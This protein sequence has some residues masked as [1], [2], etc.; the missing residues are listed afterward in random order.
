MRMSGWVAATAMF[1]LA[2][3]GVGRAQERPSK[4]PLEGNPRR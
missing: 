1:L 4:N 2:V 3:A